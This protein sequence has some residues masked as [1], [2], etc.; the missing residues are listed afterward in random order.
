M[1]IELFHAS[2]YGNGLNLAVE[3]QRQMTEKG[4]EVI[5]RNVNDFQGREIPKADLYVF[6]T[7]ARFG[8]PIRSIRNFIEKKDIPSGS[9]YA[10]ISTEMEIKPS[11]KADKRPKQE[12]VDKW[13]KILPIMNKMLQDK[14]L[15]K[16]TDMSIFVLTT[17]GPLEDGWQEK[18][19]TFVNLTGS[20]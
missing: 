10:V 17:K 4:N 6:I 2:K 7:P 18:I 20:E 8:K 9:K 16:V 14:G 13:Q 5:I 1:K 3:Y 11:K 19:T 12:S 15:F